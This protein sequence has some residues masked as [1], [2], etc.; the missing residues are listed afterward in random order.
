MLKYSET[1]IVFREVP[2]E[3][4]LAINITN[5]PHRCVGC[6]SPHLWNDI[7]EPLTAD[8][9]D[10]M[11]KDPKTG[12][13]SCIAFMGGDA[14]MEEL[15][16]LNQ[17]VKSRHPELKTCWYTGWDYSC[18]EFLDISHRIYEFDYVKIGPYIPEKGPID[19]DGS[20]QVMFKR[21]GDGLMENI[22]TRFRKTI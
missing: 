17:E 18:R 14:D 11:L 22:T 4:S 20:N 15:F 6:H 3:V 19:K 12:P 5:C 16:I 7:G 21:I 1:E 2:D 10:E 8:A 9:I 13:V